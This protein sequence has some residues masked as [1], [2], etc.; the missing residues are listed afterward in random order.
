MFPTFNGFS[1][2]DGTFITERVTFKGY[3]N[4]D[5]IT[6]NLSRR[7]GVKLLATEFREASIEVDGRLIAASASDLQTKLDNMKSSLTTEEGSLIIES[8]RTWT[9]T[10]ATMII[11]DEHYNN[12]TAPF[13][14]TFTCSNPFSTGAAQTVVQNTTSGLLNFSGLVNISGTL[15][16]RPTLV[17]TPT[18]AA[19]GHTNIKSMILTHTPTGQQVTISGFGSGMDLDYAN[20]VTINLDDF[21]GLE[22]T[23]AKDLSGSFP[24]W[25]PGSNPYT[26]AVSGNWVRATVS[27]TYSPRYL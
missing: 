26:I 20:P 14:I 10:V 12:S 8:G 9:A 23:T 15:F 21:T 3:A 19:S 13:Q 18:G 17:I 24:R 4:R 5:V 2:N 22:G 25:Q 6:Q 27:L 1:L 11:P 16:A 7:E